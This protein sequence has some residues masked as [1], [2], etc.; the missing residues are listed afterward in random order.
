MDAAS[1]PHRITMGLKV[2]RHWVGL[3]RWASPRCLSTNGN[4]TLY[5]GWGAGVFH[6]LFTIWATLE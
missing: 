6:M 3:V 2:A 1:N 4:V 5:K